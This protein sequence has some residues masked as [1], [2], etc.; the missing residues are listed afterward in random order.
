MLADQDGGGD[1][2]VQLI[3]AHPLKESFSH[4]L[5]EAAAE[6]LSSR[7]HE[8]RRTDLY[9]EGSDPC[10]TTAERASYTM[11]PYDGSAVAPHVEALRRAEGVVFCFPQWWFGMPAILKGYFDRVWAPGIAFEH[12]RAK[13]GLRPLLH[14]MKLF[15]VVTTYG[16]PWWV[17]RIW[18]QDPARHALMRGLKPMC[19]KARGLYLALY[20]LDRASDARRAEF[21]ENVRR[22]LAL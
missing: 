5:A 9:A 4:A 15:A 12:E 11:P 3:Q 21:L 10:L 20:D 7:G 1:M 18:A 2:R 6:A 13:A 19:P 22:R 16:S 14:H 8:V 17:A